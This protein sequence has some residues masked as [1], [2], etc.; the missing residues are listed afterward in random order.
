MQLQDFLINTYQRLHGGSKIEMLL[1]SPFRAIIREMVNFIL[2]HYLSHKTLIVNQ[3]KT[4]EI[5]VSLTSFPDRIDTIWQVIECMLRQTILPYKII[6]WLSNQQFRSL[7][8]IPQKLKELQNDCFEILFVEDDIRSHKKYQYVSKKYPNNLILLIDDDL[9]YPSTF[10]EDFYNAYLKEHAVIAKY[11]CIITH[12]NGKLDQYVK[13]PSSYDEFKSNDFFFGS[14]G[15]VLFVP[16]QLYK[17][18][19]NM[20]L[21]LTLCPTA[22]DVWLNAMVRLGGQEIYKL[23]SGLILPVKQKSE[24]QS[25]STINLGLDKNDEQINAIN[26]Y[27]YD[28][29]GKNIF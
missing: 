17:D 12:N 24:N 15:G 19:T 16:S 29:F 7:D 25:L 14:G 21:A 22:D 1:L 6:L 10:V 18:L 3:K 11:G 28:L 23:K 26:I 13:W 2:P 9:Y 8:E 4:D 20:Q 27:Y 5:I